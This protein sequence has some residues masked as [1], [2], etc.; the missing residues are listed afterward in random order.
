MRGAK[1]A[2]CLGSETDAPRHALTGALLGAG[3]GD[4]AVP[5]SASGPATAVDDLRQRPAG[6][7][8]RRARGAGVDGAVAQRDHAD[9]VE[10]RVDAE[11]GPHSRLPLDRDAEEAGAEA[12]V[13]GGQ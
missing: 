1:P 13:D 7:P 2:S 8:A 5:R 11:L 9:R 12:F 3:L 10:L 6:S 4:V